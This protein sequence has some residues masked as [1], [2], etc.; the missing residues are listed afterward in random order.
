[1][2]LPLPRYT[3]I[4]NAK[5]EHTGS[6]GKMSLRT[7]NITSAEELFS[8]SENL[9]KCELVRGELVMMS[10]GRG[11]HAA[12]AMRI[13]RS[14]LNFAEAHDVGMVFD[15][16]AGYVL[17]RNPDT[18]REPDVSFLTKR[19]LETQDLDAFLEGAPDL[20]IEVL[21]PGNTL[22]EMCDKMA[23]Y[24]RA[25]CRVVWIVDPRRKTIEVYRPGQEPTVLK[26]GDEVVE[27]E[28]LPGFSLPVSDVFRV[29]G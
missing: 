9:G 10:P 27:Q 13:G 2:N 26:E 8:A 7:H 23:E 21:S 5:R 18:V 11:L 12:V 1:V 20:A 14:L 17:S 29:G 28:L 24:F 3:E 19:R 4:I 22:V 15:S 6:E 16:S 25:G